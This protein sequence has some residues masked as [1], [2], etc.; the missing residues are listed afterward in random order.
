MSESLG[1]RKEHHEITMTFSIDVYPNPKGFKRPDL[2][3]FLMKGKDIKW[4]TAITFD[5][6]FEDIFTED[7]LSEDFARKMFYSYYDRIMRGFLDRQLLPKVNKK[8]KK[9]VKKS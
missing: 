7:E 4:E 3:V 8:N 2:C 9:V 5:R 6:D 1:E